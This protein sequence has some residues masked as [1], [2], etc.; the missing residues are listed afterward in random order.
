MT[1]KSQP[2]TEPSAAG[3]NIENTQGWTKK[4]RQL[5]HKLA[6]KVAEAACA[7]TPLLGEVSC[8][9]GEGEGKI[10]GW[11]VG[12]TPFFAAHVLVVLQEGCEALLL[13]GGEHAP[14]AGDLLDLPETVLA[15]HRV[16]RHRVVTDFKKR[17]LGSALRTTKPDRLTGILEGQMNRAGEC[18][19]QCSSRTKR[20]NT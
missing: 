3:A 9:V 17:G 19:G 20:S 14:D 13:L 12:A 1:G 6:F 16:F 11:I 4:I 2:V 7:H 15:V 18:S 10:K 8:E 5:R